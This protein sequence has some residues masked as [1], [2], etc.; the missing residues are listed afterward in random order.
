MLMHKYND[1]Y[2]KPFLWHI[3]YYYHNKGEDI[4]NFYVSGD[5]SKL[6]NNDL[7]QANQNEE[8][9]KNYSYQLTL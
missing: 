3:N 1:N 8:L 6:L 4:L 7:P 2:E 9:F 5:C